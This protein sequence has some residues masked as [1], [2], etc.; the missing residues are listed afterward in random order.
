MQMTFEALT[1]RVFDDYAY[2]GSYGK[3]VILAWFED[4]P[5]FTGCFIINTNTARYI[6]EETEEFEI[7]IAHDVP[8][9]YIQHA[10]D[11]IEAELQEEFGIIQA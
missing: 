4:D 9:Q 7:P 6:E 5:I 11:I 1:E 8:I 3:D 10:V 2:D